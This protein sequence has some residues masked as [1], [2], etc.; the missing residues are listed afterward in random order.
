MDAGLT[1]HVAAGQEGRLGCC[2]FHAQRRAPLTHLPQVLV[3]EIFLCD[4]Y[5]NSNVGHT[6]INQTGTF[7]FSEITKTICVKQGCSHIP[8]KQLGYLKYDYWTKSPDQV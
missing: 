6:K 8:Q 4:Y 7:A 2:P 5:S 3:V 1:K